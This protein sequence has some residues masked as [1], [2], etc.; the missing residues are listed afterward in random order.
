VE[1]GNGPAREWISEEG[2]D[3]ADWWRLFPGQPRPKIMGPGVLPDTDST[4]TQAKVH[5]QNMELNS[6]G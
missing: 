2:D 4:R 3:T 1:S 5:Y 6:G